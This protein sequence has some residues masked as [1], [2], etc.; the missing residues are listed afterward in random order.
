VACVLARAHAAKQNTSR[1]STPAA[2]QP[3]NHFRSTGRRHRPSPTRISPDEKRPQSGHA[4]RAARACGEPPAPWRACSHAPTRRSKQKPALHPGSGPTAPPLPLHRP[5]PPSKPHP[6]LPRRKAPAKR[7]R[8]ESRPSPKR[9][10]VPH[11]GVRARTRP[12]GEANASQPSPAAAATMRH[13]SRAT[14]IRNRVPLHRYRHP[15]QEP[16]RAVKEKQGRPGVIESDRGF[17]RRLVLP[18]NRD[19][20]FHRVIGSANENNSVQRR[21][22]ENGKYGGKGSRNPT[23]HSEREGLLPR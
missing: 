23:A 1:P 7:A 10:P 12:R 2:A 3:P 16:F 13:H 22:A 17:V 6:H 19:Q 4:T 20:K 9:T 8:H 5:P 18:Q 15:R 21:G 11:R 14:K